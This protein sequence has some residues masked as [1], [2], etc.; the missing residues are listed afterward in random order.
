MKNRE[1]MIRDVHRRIDAYA[2]EKKIKRARMIKVAVSVTSVC[3]AAIVSIGL[4]KGGVFT[5]ASHPLIGDHTGSDFSEPEHILNT[6]DPSVGNR[7]ETGTGNNISGPT[8]KGADPDKR[9][10]EEAAVSSSTVKA[11]SDHETE[12][13]PAQATDAPDNGETDAA[14]YDDTP[15][16]QPVPQNASEE[17]NSEPQTTFPVQQSTTNEPS[18]N[19]NGGNGYG[20]D[21]LGCVIINGVTYLQSFSDSNEYTPEEYLGNGGDFP[22]FYQGDTSVSFYT[23]KE[24]SDTVIAVFYDGSQLNLIRS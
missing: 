19:G 18:G 13:V 14:N 10:A 2:S 7:T 1:E 12:Q 6:D 3:A 16:T 4:W 9:N 15:D 5:P 17:I 21:A 11:A 22:G 20:G 8:T 24:N 23:A